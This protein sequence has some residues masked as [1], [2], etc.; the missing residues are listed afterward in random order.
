M[1]LNSFNKKQHNR[2]GVTGFDTPPSAL[3]ARPAKHTEETTV[4][5]GGT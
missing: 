4:S 2:I 3:P 1:L 5:D